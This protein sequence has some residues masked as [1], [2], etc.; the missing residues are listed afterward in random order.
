[1]RDQSETGFADLIEQIRHN[2]LS[3]S[4][5]REGKPASE[6]KSHGL[7]RSQSSIHPRLEERGLRIDSHLRFL[8][9]VATAS[10]IGCVIF[11][12]ASSSEPL[13]FANVETSVRA[14]EFPSGTV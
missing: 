2:C 5:P 14:L 6:S 13:R 12:A 9:I 7:R 3:R 11:N 4:Q 10:R 8:S 1:M